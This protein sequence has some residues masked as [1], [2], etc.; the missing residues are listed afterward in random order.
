MPPHLS[1]QVFA[2]RHSGMLH[3]PPAPPPPS[4]PPV[5]AEAE[6]P[7]LVPAELVPPEL[8]PAELLSPAL[9]PAE[10]PPPAPPLLVPPALV[11]A[12]LESEPPAPALPPSLEELEQA[13]HSARQANPRETLLLAESRNAGSMAASVSRARVASATPIQRSRAIHG[14][15]HCHFRRLVRV[16]VS[17]HEARTS[18]R[19]VCPKHGGRKPATRADSESRAGAVPWHRVANG[20]R[21]RCSETRGLRSFACARHAECPRVKGRVRCC[22]F[23]LRERVRCA[24]GNYFLQLNGDSSDTIA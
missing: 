4:L 15:R 18:E 3:E 1:T 14:P 17:V 22:M 5:P 16:R 13:K 23:G 10:L 2:T 12:W 9:V 21:I 7:A 11:P 20:G 19:R 8:V 24:L 6:P